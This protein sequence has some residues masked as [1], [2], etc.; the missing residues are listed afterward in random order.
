MY[1]HKG[2][3]P[4]RRSN[5]CIYL[6]TQSG[7]TQIYK[8]TNNKQKQLF[9]SNTIMVG[10]FNSHLQQWTDYQTENKQVNDDFERHSVSDGLNKYIQNPS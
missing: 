2:D 6:C 3:K 9:D 1:N 4:T 5:N 10:D 7:S 8:T